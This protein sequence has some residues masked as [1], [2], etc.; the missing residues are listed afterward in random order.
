[1]SSST[2]Q[3]PP[4]LMILWGAFL[5]SHFMM[6]A[7][8]WFV[9]SKN[10]P[11]GGLPPEALWV[12]TALGIAMPVIAS[13]VTR[14]LARSV[15]ATGEQLDA[16]ELRARIFPAIIVGFALKEAGAVFAFVSLI[17]FGDAI[18]WAVPA[19]VAFAAHLVGPPTQ[20]NLELLAGK[21]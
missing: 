16:D 8:A 12:I 7:A 19:G 10:G 5:M 21:R 14:L 13:M 20:R 11:T 9:V 6:G 15:R 4:V 17:L 18:W 3:Q 1:M 2:D